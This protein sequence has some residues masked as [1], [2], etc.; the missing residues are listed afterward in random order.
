[1]GELIGDRQ[2]QHVDVSHAKEGRSE[3]QVSMPPATASMLIIRPLVATSSHHRNW[4]RSRS[5]LS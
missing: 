5:R 3:Y 2:V 4:S 1:M